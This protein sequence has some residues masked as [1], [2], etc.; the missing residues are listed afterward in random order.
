MRRERFF[1][2]TDRGWAIA[3]V[4]VM[5]GWGATK[6]IG[7]PGSSNPFRPAKE[8]AVE[9]ILRYRNEH[10]RLP[11]SWKAVAAAY[12]DDLTFESTFHCETCPWDHRDSERL[13][14]VVLNPVTPS[15]WKGHA[16]YEFILN[17]EFDLSLPLYVRR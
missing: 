9:L 2:L 13:D 5:L 4:L 14:Q 12:P 1:G 8:K 6:M 16:Q 7:H 3:W 10:G 15:D 17:G 11:G